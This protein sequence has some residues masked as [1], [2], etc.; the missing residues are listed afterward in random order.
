V[1]L[2]NGAASHCAAGRGLGCAA[3]QLTRIG[4]KSTAGVIKDVVMLGGFQEVEF[5]FLAD[6]PAPPLLHDIN[7]C[8]WTSA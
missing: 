2:R 8:T 3:D 4:G 5:D 6:N 1:R 7:S